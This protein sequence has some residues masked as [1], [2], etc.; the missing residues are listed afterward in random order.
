MFCSLKTHEKGNE[1]VNTVRSGIQANGASGEAAFRVKYVGV[2][3]VMYVHYS[4]DGIY[5]EHL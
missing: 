1:E 5:F 2:R 4:G 3:R